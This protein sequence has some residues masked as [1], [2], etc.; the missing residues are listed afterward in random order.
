M[1]KKNQRN[2]KKNSYDNVGS[3]IDKN[4]KNTKMKQNY[5][6]NGQIQIYNSNEYFINPYTFIPIEDKEPI[7]KKFFPKTGEFAGEDSLNKISGYLECSLEVKSP[8]FI[9][10]TSK[11]FKLFKSLLGK[12]EKKDSCYFDEFF[13]YQDLSNCKVSDQLGG[14]YPENEPK[15]PRIPGSEI[16]GVIR[17]IYEQLTNSCLSVIDEKN[18]PYKRNSSPKQ[19]G[20]LNVKTGDLY[21]AE[22]L[23]LN[24]GHKTGNADFGMQVNKKGDKVQYKTGD[25]VYVK[26]TTNTYITQKKDRKGNLK[27][28]DIETKGVSEIIKPETKEDKY[29]GYKQ[30][31]VLIGE[32]FSDKK[33]HDSVLIFP[34]D[35]IEDNTAI[36]ILNDNDINRFEEVLKRYQKESSE[37][38]SKKKDPHKEYYEI[39]QDKKS[40]ECSDPYL[41]VF[42]SMVVDKQEKKNIYYLSPSMIT[43]EVFDKT[44]SKLLQENHHKHQPCDGSEGWCPACRLFGMVGKSEDSSQAVASKLRFSDSS[45]IEGAEFE[46]PKFLPILGTPRYSSTEFYLQKP[47]ENADMWN[48]DYHINVGEKQG[49][50]YQAILKGRKVY[51]LGDMKNFDLI[52]LSDIDDERK[53]LNAYIKRKKGKLPK[54]MTMKE[55]FSLKNTKDYIESENINVKKFSGKTLNLN[56]LKEQIN[57]NKSR[58]SNKDN[59]F[60]ESLIASFD[61]FKDSKKDSFNEKVSISQLRK[62]LIDKYIEQK[63][64]NMTSKVRRLKQGSCSF[65]VYF[66]HIT[67]KELSALIFCLDLEENAMHRIGRGKPYGMG[68]VKIKVN[69]VK[70]IKYKIENNN[71]IREEEEI[72]KENFKLSEVDEKIKESILKYSTKLN[73]RDSKLVDYPIAYNKA[74]EQ[75][76]IFRWF[77]ENR[78]GVNSE[79][80]KKTL[81]NILDDNLSLPQYEIKK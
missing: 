48:Y 3:N 78:G 20:I 68:A 11:R 77:G 38:K 29:L 16:R 52:N 31:Y 30:G 34:G 25:L 63:K 51:W 43:K 21:Q 60:M 71:V 67:E 62:N 14:E 26:S 61:F 22:R 79:K 50:S 70:K 80:I 36:V 74:G 65:K 56:D 35:K 15:Y 17:N 41:P 45:V 59:R 57:E 9:P 66:D 5:F 69:K 46:M 39:Y 28:I 10:N 7:R 75:L 32:D 76:E 19:A 33:H 47:K 55:L 73:E 4:G 23:M 54:E 42:Y 24:T 12:N 44:I 64:L 1:G 53:G 81:P 13:S 8:L 40:G 2:V 18:L 49:I 37:K 72:G 27:K 6:E 58:N